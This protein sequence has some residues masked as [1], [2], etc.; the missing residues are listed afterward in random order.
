MDNFATRLLEACNASD[1]IPDYG[2]GQQT[3]IAARLNV[4][5]EAVRKWLAGET[6]PRAALSKRLAAL[7]GVKHSWLMLGTAHGEIE[8]DIKLARRHKSCVYAVMTYVVGAGMGA[9]F[10][11][12]DAVD[13]ITL[14]DGGRLL[15]VSVEMSDRPSN[16]VYEV[17][18]SESQRNAGVTVAVVAEYQSQRSAAMDAL[19][20]TDEIWK[21][22]GKISGRECVLRF[23]KSARGSTYSVG[24]T[25][26]RKFLES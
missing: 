26:I 10:S 20:I 11:G 17:K 2:K 18:F 19:E 5:Q 13:D 16:G 22:H 4:S 6:V 15:R 12:D 23:E 8:V 21:K 14:I 7:L 24:G 25:K 1:E 3:A 9:T